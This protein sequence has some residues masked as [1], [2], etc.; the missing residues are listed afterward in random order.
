MQVQPEFGSSLMLA[1][2]DGA[3]GGRRRRLRH[4]KEFEYRGKTYEGV[5][6]VMAFGSGRNTHADETSTIG[7]FGFGLST[8]IV[9]QARD[10][11]V[12]RV[13]T[14]QET[15]ED[16]RWSEYH[17]DRVVANKCGFRQN[18]WADWTSFRHGTREPS[19]SSTL[20]AA[21]MRPGAHQSRILAW[22]GRVYREMIAQGLTITVIGR[23]GTKDDTKV[24]TL[25]DP[26]ALMPESKEAKELGAVKEYEVL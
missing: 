7:R 14:K 18:S 9:S 15:D 25:R 19:L 22:V 6:F 1:I 17:F 26:L 10:Q 13:Y 11:G 8:A 23:T 16:W 2:R 21:G 3:F 24:A 20:P 5:P 12:G 4:P